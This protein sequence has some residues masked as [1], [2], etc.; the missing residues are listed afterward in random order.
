M[1]SR[2]RDLPD[3]HHTQGRTFLE[4]LW[5][6]CGR[7]LDANAAHHAMVDMP[8]VFWELYLAHALR[9]SG[10]NIV[11]Q[12]RGKKTQRGPDLFAVDPEV[13]IEAVVANPG[14]GGDALQAP[15][16]GAVYSVPVDSFILRLRSVIEA[17]SRII[18]GYIQDKIIQQE[19]AAVIAISG[20][21]LYTQFSEQPIPRIVRAA[22]GVGNL[23]VDV[24]RN[25]EAT[26]GY[27]VEESV[28]IEKCT[29]ALVRTDVFL[30]SEYAHIS[31]LIYS[32]SDWVNTPY[33][34]GTEFIVIHNENARV[35]LPHGWLPV[36]DEYWLEQT[37]LRHVRRSAT[38]N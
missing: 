29:G 33:E 8:P 25:R 27:S 13:W 3:K 12:N 18:K 15:P 34:P 16:L 35:K 24:N 11:E 20:C 5:Q 38:D 22:L 32:A 23:V 21:M 31:A 19:Q 14:S 17:K 10:I 28:Q 30:N 1:Y 36:G 6:E 4:Q 9:R 37:A 2:A 26:A 7:F